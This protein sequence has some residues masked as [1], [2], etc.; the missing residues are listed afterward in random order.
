VYEGHC[1][2]C[3]T[4]HRLDRTEAAE[5]TARALME[6]LAR[7]PLCA[8][9]KMYGVLLATDSG[10][11]PVELRAFSG[12]ISG[13]LALPG[14]APP[15]PQEDTSEEEARVFARLA[16]IRREL[17]RLGA[18]PAPVEVRR[19]E[20]DYER[21][22]KAH[23]AERQRGKAR[24]RALRAAGADP[25]PLDEASRLEGI[26]RR[27]LRR[28]RKLALEPLK[29]RYD[30]VMERAR[31]LKRERRGLSH[32]LQ[33]KLHAAFQLP[34][35]AGVTAGLAEAF[36]G[37][38]PSGAAECC[39]PKLLVWA[40]R[41][42]LRP[43]AMAEFWWGRPSKDGLKEP[44]TFYGPCAE[45]CQP[46]MGHL[47]CDGGLPVVYQDAH[48]MVVDKP[49]GLAS[50]P[51]RTRDA[52]DSV[53]SRAR[54]RFPDARAAHRLDMDTSG[55]LLVALDA[56]SLRRLSIAFERRLVEKRYVAVLEGPPACADGV[57]ELRSSPDPTALPRQRIDPAG[58]LGRT[59]YRVEDGARVVFLPQTGRTHQIRLAAL[60]GLGQSIV[61]DRLYGRPAARLL[62][63]AAELRL[64]HPIINAPIHLESAVPF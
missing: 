25:G 39:A 37:P 1:E 6:E 44:G 28:E 24:R 58:K 56:L 49:A 55:L 59:E 12:R 46:I 41:R 14:W 45:R 48:L 15:V 5:R 31:T 40:T 36:D 64:R 26:A 34:N 43:Q 18:D 27:R 10:G 50:V 11:A 32:A 20:A 53:Q 13:A 57:I 42:G 3:G 60:H 16:S 7:A 9:G 30:E 54:L 35:L 2:R 22:L 4:T 17:T 29:P 51:G 61:G 52:Q 23:N 33:A 21:R 8:E 47:L 63:H 38:P 62:L 19:I